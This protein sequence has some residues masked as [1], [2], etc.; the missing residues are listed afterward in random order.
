MSRSNG[1][2]Q[3]TDAPSFDLSTVNSKPPVCHPKRK[4]QM[5][6]DSF[7]IEL[8]RCLDEYGKSAY[9]LAADSGVDVGNLHRI[10]HGERQN[11][12]RETILRIALGMTL[13]APQVDEVIVA[14][15]RLFDAAGL[16]TL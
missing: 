12:T 1:S 4:L 3:P 14:I 11:T 15:N 13:P 2:A 10:L 7:A 8:Q 5:P 9:R 16:K 6:A